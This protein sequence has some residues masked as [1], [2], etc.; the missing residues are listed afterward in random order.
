MLIPDTSKSL[1]ELEGEN[2]GEPNYDSHLVL[3]CHRL[4]RTPLCDFTVADYRRMIGQSF[5]LDFLAP[6]AIKR[7]QMEPFAEGEYY[8]GDLLCALLKADHTFWS[9]H[10]D[11]KFEMT[12]IARQVET[13]LNELSTKG[14]RRHV[15]EAIGQFE[16]NQGISAHLV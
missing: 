12:K 2:W 15:T 6:L 5:C 3:E 1:E 14:E 16:R 9:S 11:L 13:R 10:A 4:H 7:L 8:E